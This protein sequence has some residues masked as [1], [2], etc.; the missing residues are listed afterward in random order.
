MDKLVSKQMPYS[1]K[2][3]NQLYDTNQVKIHFKQN[4]N[5]MHASWWS[6]DLHNTSLLS[7]CEPSTWGSVI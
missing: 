7:N 5:T 1:F 4:I 2:F 3:L 6:P